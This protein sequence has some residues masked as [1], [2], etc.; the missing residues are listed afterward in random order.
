MEFADD[1]EIP[2]FCPQGCG[3]LTEDPY[4]G[5]CKRCW[6]AVGRG[7][8]EVADYDGRNCAGCIGAGPCD[9]G[10]E[11]S[12]G[13]GRLASNEWGTCVAC[14]DEVTGRDEDSDKDEEEEI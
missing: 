9:D 5:P 10:T 6:G 4:G 3:G 14:E 13:C 1:A 11:C 12:Y 8:G 2:N 7:N